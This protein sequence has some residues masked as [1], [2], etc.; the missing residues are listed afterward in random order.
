VTSRATFNAIGGLALVGTA[1]LLAATVAWAQSSGG[2]GAASGP[3]APSLQEAPPILPPPRPVVAP[4]DRR[5]R[6]VL[7]DRPEVPI[8]TPEDYAPPAPASD[9]PVDGSTVVAQPCRIR[10]DPAT[11]WYLLTFLPRRGEQ[12]A[13][14]T[15]R[16]LLPSKELEAVERELAAERGQV[17]E[18]GRVGQRT[19]A[20]E[21]G[22]V[23]EEGRA[24]PEPGAFE[25]SGETTVYRG[26]SFFAITGLARPRAARIDNRPPAA[27]RTGPEARTT[28]RPAAEGGASGAPASSPA[29]AASRPFADIRTSADVI[30]ARLL[31]D[32]PAQPVHVPRDP[33]PPSAA[34]SVAP[35]VAPQLSEDRGEMRIDRLVVISGPHADYDAFMRAGP[36]D[37]EG[38]WAARFVSDNTLQDQPVRLLPCRL[39]MVAEKLHAERRRAGKTARFR[40]S[41]IITQYKGGQYMLLR[42]A[43]VER[44]LGQF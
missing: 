36:G 13:P 12:P 6:Q 42:K 33:G 37:S 15:P 43:V 41:G 11:G 30:A 22:Q 2:D 38:W 34:P 17:G 26:K 19:L 9:L 24:R 18:E 25:V 40:V 3:G 29:T 8:T 28:S 5:F 14:T 31:A 20:A 44:D 7:T 27:A 10:L 23:G 16:W 21:R 35:S 39:L 32:R 1:V 4:E